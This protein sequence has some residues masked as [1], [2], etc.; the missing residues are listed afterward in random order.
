MPTIGLFNRSDPVE[1]KK[2]APPKEKMPPSLATSQYPGAGP[3]TAAP[4]T[5]GRLG[6]WFNWPEKRVEPKPRTAPLTSASR[7][8][9][10]A[11]PAGAGSPGEGGGVE[12]PPEAGVVVAVVTLEGTVV[13]VVGDVG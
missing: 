8:P 3:G 9:G 12:E 6:I 4:P 5:T 2:R 13:A 10:R 11:V 7:Y 1:P